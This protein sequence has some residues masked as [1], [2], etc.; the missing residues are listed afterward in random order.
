[1]MNVNGINPAAGLKAVEPIG[2]VNAAA[3][4]AQPAA[5]SDVIEISTAAKLAAKIHDIPDI[6]ADLVAR[7]RSE[8][9]AGTYETPERI[10]AAVDRLM[11]EIS[12]G[13]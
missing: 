5:V 6:R 11:D 3:A 7:V 10:D 9:E 4:P 2:T 13:L 1:M 12:S 8:I